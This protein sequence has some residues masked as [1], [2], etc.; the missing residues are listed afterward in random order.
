MTKIKHFLYLLAT[1]LLASVIFAACTQ[2]PEVTPAEEEPTVK[3]ISVDPTGVKTLFKSG[4]D[5]FTA[6]GLKVTAQW[7]G[8]KKATEVAA[9]DYTVSGYEDN[10]QDGKLVITN[11]ANYQE[12]TITVTY[13][14]KTDT[15]TI[16]ISDTPVEVKVDLSE[17]QTDYFVGDTVDKTKFKVS[18][19][20]VEG[21]EEISIDSSVVSFSTEKSGSISVKASINGV[22]SEPFTINV[23]EIKG[24]NEEAEFEK[25]D[26]VPPVKVYLGEEEAKAEDV[27]VTFYD[28]SDKV[29]ENSTFAAGKYTLKITAG[30]AEKVFEID[31]KRPDAENF[32]VLADETKIEGAALQIR[33]DASDMNVKWAEHLEKVKP[34]VTLSDGTVSADPGA[35]F[36]AP[37]ANA[38]TGIVE[39]F[40]IQIV[41][42]SPVTTTTAEISA[43]IAGTKYKTTV[44]FANEKFI[45]SDYVPTELVLD[46]TTLEL[47]CGATTTFKVTDKTYGLD[48]SSDVDWSLVDEAETGSTIENG[49]FTAG[50]VEETATV[51]VKASL[52][53]KPEVY[54]EATVKINPAKEDVS[55]IFGFELSNTIHNGA[56]FFGKITWQNDEYKVSE[57]SSKSTGVKLIKN[58]VSS[59]TESSATF[60]VELVDGTYRGVTKTFVFRVKTES[61]AYY[62]VSVT[63][64]DKDVTASG[65]TTTIDEVSVE[66]A[67][68][69]PKITLSEE[70]IAVQKDGEAVTVE[71]SYDEI[72]GFDATKLK[73]VSDNAA[74]TV[75]LSGT[76]LSVT[77]SAAAE[78]VKVTVTYGE[79]E[80]VKA[81]LNV[82]VAEVV[83]AAPW[84]ITVANITGAGGEFTFAW[85]DAANELA[86]NESSI[87]DFKFGTN[88][89]NGVGEC[90]AGKENGTITAYMH[91]IGADWSS[92]GEK[93]FYCKVKTVSGAICDINGT[94][95]I[96]GNEGKV[97]DATFDFV[98]MIVLSNTSLQFDEVDATSDVTVSSL[99]FEFDSSK[100]SASSSAVD[101]AT[102]SVT[103]GV[104][105]IT[106]VAA[107]D[108]VITVSYD[109]EGIEDKTIAVHVGARENFLKN[110]TPSA[111]RGNT[112]ITEEDG[113]YTVVSSDA[114]GGDWDNQIYFVGDKDAL[115]DGD[116]VTSSVTVTVNKACT[117]VY[118]VEINT[119]YT[120]IAN[121]EV[122]HTFA[123]AGTYTFEVSGKI[124]GHNEIKPLF[125]LRSH[126]AGLELTIKDLIIYKN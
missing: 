66:E 108:A 20:Y 124:E 45:P 123:E 86:A 32:V 80:T 37:V 48:Y 13:S 64:T 47:A 91:T 68:L 33:V 27:S 7:T 81:E 78:N 104:V 18:A 122:S 1:M 35:F 100:V 43:D 82:T 70:S 71:V 25:G 34:E 97:N 42:T 110:V 84:K 44:R 85:T 56:V 114:S 61:G 119:N 125:A 102:V 63:Y 19:I 39:A 96:T 14:G 87:V 3:S 22:E 26:P 107:G 117:L 11:G 109:K 95:K 74:V 2:D 126:E 38:D 93:A 15:Y 4:E 21:G 106:A 75:S 53:E 121:K 16:T 54:A 62:D 51:T 98:S 30:D 6:E 24:F 116:S 50:T 41:L 52:K 23:Y 67:V 31:V 103:D 40:T 36:T 99:G 29:Y 49:T 55:S 59:T 118:K 77:G 17:A 12:V 60:E 79:S 8:K 69:N 58:F 112:T 9:T 113:V 28:S 10:V 101:V 88:A 105:T 90:K 115:A 65:S 76:T 5:A 94:L 57:I 46:K 89:K 120:A 83:V 73:A 72:A 92:A 111:Q